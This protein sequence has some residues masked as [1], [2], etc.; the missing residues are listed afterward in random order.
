MMIFISPLPT[1]INDSKGLTMFRMILLLSVA[2][3]LPACSALNTAAGWVQENDQGL[4]LIRATT[5]E[6]VF[7]SDPLGSKLVCER[8]F[9]WAETISKVRSTIDNDLFALADIDTEL[10][11]VITRAGLNPV[12]ASILLDVGKGA[13]EKYKSSAG[14][15]A[16]PPDAKITIYGLLDASLS[17]VSMARAGC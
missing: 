10:Y 17:V 7:K 9:H 11:G 13:L 8:A 12:T 6:L 5:A 1:F 14:V 16:I 3:M 15:G 2:L 4:I